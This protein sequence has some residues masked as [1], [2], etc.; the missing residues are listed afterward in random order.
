MESVPIVDATRGRVYIRYKEMGVEG[1]GDL[2]TPD[3]TVSCCNC[4]K[5]GLDD[6]S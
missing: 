4:N 6:F 3:A 5:M 2:P 1:G